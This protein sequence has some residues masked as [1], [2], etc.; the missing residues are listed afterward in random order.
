MKLELGSPTNHT[1]VNCGAGVDI[2]EVTEGSRISKERGKCAECGSTCEFIQL[3]I[4]ATAQPQNAPSFGYHMPITK[5]AEVIR[6]C[7][8][9]NN[10]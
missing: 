4:I 6:G 5:A 10:K 1:C 7:I 9:R 8:E 3:L 2:S